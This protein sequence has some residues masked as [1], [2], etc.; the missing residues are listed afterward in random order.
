[1]NQLLGSVIGGLL[2]IWIGDLVIKHAPGLPEGPLAHKMIEGG[3]T[4]AGAAT[5]YLLSPA[6]TGPTGMG[7][8]PPQTAGVPR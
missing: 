6:S 4:I 2:G 8:L 7:S 3:I 1:M 5:G